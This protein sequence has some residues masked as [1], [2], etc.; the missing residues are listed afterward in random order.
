MKKTFALLLTLLL[1]LTLFSGCSGE[2][3]G[4]EDEPAAE[5]K[6]VLNIGLNSNIVGLDPLNGS[7]N[8]ARAYDYAVFE[9]LIEYDHE[10]TKSTFTPC[11]ATEWHVEDDNMTWVFKLREGVTF[12]NG[13]PFT[14]ADVVTTYTRLLN[15]KSLNVRSSYWTYLE[16]V[17]ADGDYTVKIKTTQPF[18]TTLISVAMTPIL[19]DEAYAEFGE[20]FWNAQKL[21]GTGPWKFDEWVDGAYLHL[22]KNDDYWNKSVYDPTIKEIY[23]RFL[24]EVSTAITSHISGDLDAYIVNG[25]ISKDLL[26]MY[27]GHDEIEL[28]TTETQNWIYLGY[29]CAGDSAFADYY[30]RAA[31]DY[32]IDRELICETIFSGDAKLSSGVLLPNLDG[33][34][35]SIPNYEYNPEKAKEML[36]KSN[37]DGHEITIYTSTSLAKG[38]DQILAISQMLNEVGFNTKA[39]TIESAKLTELRKSG[40]YEVFLMNDNLMGADL[41][42]YLSM[43]VLTDAHKHEYDNPEMMELVD[44][45][46]TELDIP[47]RNAMLRDFVRMMRET[48]APHTVLYYLVQTEAINKG[49][50]NIEMWKD[51]MYSVKYV[52]YDA[53]KAK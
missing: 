23:F 17:E 32:A 33:Y 28:I 40:D 2:K 31:V 38:K 19:P 34:D 43:K 15:E 39:E 16:S 11:L 1:A 46:L 18:A 45:I 41:S 42:K 49:V 4:E 12:H 22:V 27:A 47:T 51:T 13:E 14:S 9:P 5:T 8:S 35:P 50:V 52:D 7:S 26:S 6:T 21:Y 24:T 25:G 20:D 30:A 53:S 48:S 44:K 10:G 3:Q 36:A 37:Y 29:H